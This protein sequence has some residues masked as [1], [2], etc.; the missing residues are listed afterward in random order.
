MQLLRERDCLIAVACLP[1]DLHI[2]LGPDD[3]GE[4]GTDE[5]LVVGDDHA[6]VLLLIHSLHCIRR[7][8][9]ALGCGTVRAQSHTA[10]EA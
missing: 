4:S 9:R 6:D 5:F 3:H 8:G 10:Y 1:D 2:R 7:W